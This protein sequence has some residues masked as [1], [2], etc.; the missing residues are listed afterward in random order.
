MP[1][2]PEKQVNAS[3]VMDKQVY[4]RLKAI[5]KKNKRSVSAQISFWVEQMIVK[6]EQIDN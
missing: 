2:D 4:A 6:E 5:A 3:V 1:I